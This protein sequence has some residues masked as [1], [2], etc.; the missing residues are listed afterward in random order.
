MLDTGSLVL[1][2]LCLVRPKSACLLMNICILM[3]KFVLRAVAINLQSEHRSVD[4]TD[5]VSSVVVR[6]YLMTMG[7][8]PSRRV[9]HCVCRRSLPLRRD[10]TTILSRWILLFR[11]W[12]GL[13]LQFC[14]KRE[15]SIRVTSLM[16]LINQIC[17]LST[18]T[19]DPLGRPSIST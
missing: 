10:G 2:L 16:I 11:F 7:Q 18:S 19:P 12:S 8:S 13:C 5:Q 14:Q 3:S 6:N 9:H 15:G 4:C 1:Q 17:H